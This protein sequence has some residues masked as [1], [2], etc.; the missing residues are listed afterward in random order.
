M[1]VQDPSPQGSVAPV[2]LRSWPKVVMMMPTLFMAI[3]CGMAM[4]FF[5]RPAPDA[6][7]N[8]VHLLNL[9]FLLVLAFNLIILLYDLSLRGFLI[10][11]LLV[12]SLVLAVFLLDRSGGLWQALGRAFG[13]RVYANSAFY[14]LLALILLFNMVIAWVITR[15]QYWV[16]DHNEIIIHRGLMQE[17][18]RHPT[19]RARF[20]MQIDDIIEY[21]LFGSGNLVFTFGDE[22]KE[23]HLTTV[24]RIRSKAEQLDRLLGRLAVTH[25]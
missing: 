14:F 10:V 4:V 5:D 13:R 1:A 18:E 12:V 16:V 11:V 7:F 8:H 23:H 20:T 22:K 9:V 25:Q 3:I 6:E 21:G 19:N 17:Q 2:I 24:L 15:F